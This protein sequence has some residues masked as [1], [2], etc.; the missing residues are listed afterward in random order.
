MNPRT[1][2]IFAAVAALA[3][4]LA[5]WAASRDG[6]G[7]TNA[8]AGDAFLP[9]LKEQINEIVRIELDD[10]VTPIQYEKRGVAW[11][12]PG[13]GGYPVKTDE[14]KR[15]LLGLYALE[16][17]EAKTAKPERHAEL[18]L[19]SSG[20]A[21]ERGKLLRLWVAGKEAPTWELVI[22]Q[23]KWSP[24]R[25]IY[26]RL[27]GDDQCWFV[28]GEV[29][30]PYQPTAWLDKE[31]A[32]ANQQD[33][34]SILL[35]RGND[36]FSL[37]RADDATPWSLAELPEGRSLKEFSPFGALGNV[38]GYLN[39]DDV[40]PDSDERFARG[41]DAVAEFGF[42]HGGSIRMEGW[43]LGDEEA[44]ELW[45][46]LASAPPTAEL[47]PPPAYGADGP[48]DGPRGPS[49][50]TLAQ[51]ESKWHGW[52]YKLP[53]WKGSALLQGL[54]DWLE[55]LPEPEP[56]PEAAVEPVEDEDSGG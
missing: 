10:G 5:W 3:L 14:I 47:P 39:F 54:E 9:G 49:A 6:A 11:V 18:Q 8:D 48:Q 45:V 31:V 1:L 40:A 15:L 55:P 35:V 22:G 26:A 24:V 56:E 44:P 42:F 28:A 36:H 4:I 27:A 17:R 32:N 21:D 20:E 53:Q 41:P 29:S 13:R 46:R 25:G 51:W 43:K 2:R 16:K 7:S 34:A 23:S 19:A 30:L 33:V 52:I 50:E 38:L 12:D 37:S